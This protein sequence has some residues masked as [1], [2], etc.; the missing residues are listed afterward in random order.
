MKLKLNNLHYI[1]LSAFIA[2]IAVLIFGLVIL[3]KC[4]NTRDLSKLK[5]DDI[6]SGTY[7]KGQLTTVVEGG[8]RPNDTEYISEPYELYT[9]DSD[10]ISE[11]AYTSYFLMELENDPGKYVCVV[12]DQYLY[13]DLYHQIFSDTP[14]SEKVPCDV[15]GVITAR[16]ADKKLVKDGVDKLSKKYSD[17]Y[18]GMHYANDVTHDNVSECIIEL[19]PVGARK[20]WWLYSIPLLFAGVSVF[21][22]GG[23]PYERIK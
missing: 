11:G 7:V 23:R 10:E 17:Y 19:R 1:G 4:I 14:E 2:G 5:F 6:K 21:I 15:E 13:T 16:K 9:T 3:A 18:Y 8:Y 22:L 20:L 12:I